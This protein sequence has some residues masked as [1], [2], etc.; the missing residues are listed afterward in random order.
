[1]YT[2]NKEER[3]CSKKLLEKL[4]HSG[5][6]F[7]LYPYRIVWLAEKF[8]ADVPAQ[9]VI[10]VSK[11]KFKKAVERNLIKRRIREIYR[12]NKSEFLYPYLSK[13]ELQILLAINYIGKDISDYALMEKK[14]KL[15][16]EQLR[17]L[18]SKSNEE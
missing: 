11:R 17:N 2:F 16:L 4:F 8:A 12:L 5:S 14:L 9:V 3:L 10:S 1:M 13:S 6:S 15:A 7:L 18:S